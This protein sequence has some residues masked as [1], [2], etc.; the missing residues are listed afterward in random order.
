MAN[1]SV[2]AT[3]IVSFFSLSQLELEVLNLQLFNF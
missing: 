3:S 1:V 2:L